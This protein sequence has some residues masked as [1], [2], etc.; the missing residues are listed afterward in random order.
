M[1]IERIFTKEDLNRALNKLLS[2]KAFISEYRVIEYIEQAR[3]IGI[4]EVVDWIKSR[5]V[6]HD[7]LGARF[8]ASREEW[9]D[10]LKE[11]GLDDSKTKA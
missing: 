7:V 2:D 1:K 8:Y 11:W 4:K 3:L 5:E 6:N 9:Q 10:K